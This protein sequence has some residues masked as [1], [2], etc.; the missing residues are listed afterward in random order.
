MVSINVY[1][2]SCAAL[3][4]ICV[5]NYSSQVD[6]QAERTCNRK[7]SPTA[8]AAHTLKLRTAGIEVRAPSPKANTSQQAAI[9]IEGP[10]DP[11][12][13]PARVTRGSVGSCWVCVVETEACRL[14]RF[15]EN[16][17]I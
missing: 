3:N 2:H 17:E 13:K 9:V 4:V 8:I 11:R 14:Y 10:A 16:F 6:T 1:M 7:S 12:A 5:C 15:R